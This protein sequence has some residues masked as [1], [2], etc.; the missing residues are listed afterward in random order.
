MDGLAQLQSKYRPILEIGQGGMSRVYLA[1]VRGPGD[2]NKLQV[3]KRLLPTLAADPE[4]LEMFLEEARLSAR[5]NHANIVQINEIGFDG[6][7]HFMAMEYLEGQTLDAV[8][9]SAAKRGTLPLA[10]HLRIIADACSGLHYAHALTD[11]DGKPLNIVHRDVSPHNVFV[12]YAGQVKVLDFGIAKAA[13]SS[14]HTRTGVVKGKCAYMAPEQFRQEGIDRRA[15]IFALGVMTWQ[16]AT[17][18]RLWKGLTDIEIFHRLATGE[19]PS[20]LSIDPSMP[21]GLV[22]ICERA[23]APNR[24][25]RFST[26]QELGEAIEAYLA[27]LPE[28]PS[29]REIGR[30]VTDLF[31][32]NRAKVK[33]AI[34]AERKRSETYPAN[35]GEIPIFVDP[36]AVRDDSNSQPVAGAA[37]MT[38]PHTTTESKISPADVGRG[39]ISRLKAF[40][41]V[42]GAVV[43]VGGGVLGALGWRKSHQVAEATPPAVTSAASGAAAQQAGVAGAAGANEPLVGGAAADTFT[44]LKVEVIPHS[45]SVFVDDV[46]LSSN[47]AQ[48]RFTR[49]KQAHRVLGEAPGYSRQVQLVVYDEAEKQLT[50]QLERDGTLPP[51][52]AGGHAP[53]PRNTGGGT[54][55]TGGGGSVPS[56]GATPSVTQAPTNV[57]PQP[58]PT[59]VVTQTHA[60]QPSNPPPPSVTQAPAPPPVSAPAPGTVDHKGVRATVAAHRGEVQACYDRAHLERNDLHGKVVVSATI[61]PQGQVLN[62][63]VAN[64]TANSTRLE[65]CLISAFQGW[66]F[67]APAGGVNGNVTYTFNFD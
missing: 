63:G 26:A 31:A 64:S 61:N 2:F 3:I 17:R 46:P 1:L 28:V 15:D 49:D 54:R 37:P 42:G 60:P 22:A 50:I 18:T 43:L 7:H 67:P 30:Y 24:D 66:T 45:A 35:T 13:D 57:Q 48:A 10:M 38:A 58:A 65:Q 11:I 40:V 8:V 33:A 41:L 62:A 21:T 6:Q 5:L 52:T 53:P 20:P 59:P 23:L 44:V 9:R 4:F 32:E 51:P 27:T 12:T 19:I 47:P 14:H 55:H 39:G 16:A 34:E 25:Q 29:T 36:D 56:T